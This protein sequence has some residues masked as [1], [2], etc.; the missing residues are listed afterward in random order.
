MIDTSFRRGAKRLAVLACALT[1]LATPLVANDESLIPPSSHTIPLSPAPPGSRAASVTDPIPLRRPAQSDNR[2]SHS[3][4]FSKSIWN[5]AVVLAAICAGLVLVSIGLRRRR[6]SNGGRLPIE[7]IEVLGRTAVDGRHTISL[8]R[9]GSR[10][11]VLAADATGGLSTLAEISEP[12][13]V[14]L[15]VDLCHLPN[16]GVAAALGELPRVVGDRLGSATESVPAESV[17]A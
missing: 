11:L 12:D 7:A 13:E 8:V 2:Q 16:G 10:V 1:L 6:R 5:A 9:C 3:A 15:L 17:H 4:R 14:N